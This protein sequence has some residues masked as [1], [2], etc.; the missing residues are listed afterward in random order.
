MA[1]ASAPLS[2]AIA[3]LPLATCGVSDSIEAIASASVCNADVVGSL[4]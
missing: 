1:A 3:S 2:G 4:D